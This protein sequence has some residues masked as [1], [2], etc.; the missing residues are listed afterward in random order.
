MRRVLPTAPSA[1]AAVAQ[2]A[3]ERIGGP[4]GRQSA[5]TRLIRLDQ[6]N[7]SSG[8]MAREDVYPTQTRST[9]ARGGVCNEL[10]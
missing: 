6:C 7:E 3:L 1:T 5:G 9:K 4:L 10:K 8:K 2:Q